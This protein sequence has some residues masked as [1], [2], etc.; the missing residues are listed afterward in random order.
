MTT[1]AINLGRPAE[2]LGEIPGLLRAAG[3]DLR[4]G[5][6][7]RS[8]P[9]ADVIDS[10]SGCTVV[11]AGQELYTAAVFDGCPSLRLVVRFGVGFDNV[12]LAAATDRRVLVAT[13]PGTNDWAVAD[14]T[15]GMIL[16]LAHGISSQDRDMRRQEWR[17]ERGVDV[18]R[19]TLG[20]V[21]LG[22]IG[23]AVARRARGFEMRVIAREPAPDPAFC[24]E[25]GVE[26]R[27]L[28]DVFSEA[29]FIS[30]HLPVLAETQKIVDRALLDLMKPTAFLVNCARGSLV[31][32]DALYD[33]LRSG[34]IAG[35]GIDAWTIEPMLAARW[36]ELEN[37]VLTPHSA[38]STDSVWRATGA[39]VVDI[40]L[41]V[42]SGDRPEQLLNPEAWTEPAR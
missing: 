12:D 36:A 40:L 28:E 2:E 30:L 24:A 15:L 8:T 29:D 34:R 39:M 3:L 17:P 33:A 16:D 6:G 18:W 11:I 13:T 31:D 37:V 23:R 21:G 4:F 20:I 26:L 1:V 19:A 10:V 22:R 25:H 35:A 32:E 7:R 14:H 41:K 9:L 5:S 38:A 42:L 27:S